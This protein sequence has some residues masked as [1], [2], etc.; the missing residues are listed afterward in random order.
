MKAPLRAAIISGFLHAVAFCGMATAGAVPIVVEGN[1]MDGLWPIPVKC[2]VPFPQGVLKPGEPVV[3]VDGAGVVQSAQT[4]V[5]ATWDPNGEK[6][7]RWL[8]L[9]FLAGK[10]KSYR[11]LFG[12][13][14]AG[15]TIPPTGAIGRI[16]GGI[17][18]IDTG[19]LRATCS[20]RKFDLLASLTGP[21]GRLIADGAWAGAYLEHEKRGIF[22]A[23]L[24]PDA[25]VILEETGPVRA[26]VR[27][28]GWYVNGTGE[29][30]G[31]YIVRV[32]FFRGKADIKVEHTF[33][34]TG[35]AQED[36]LRDIG[37][38][39]PLRQTKTV[40]SY[41]HFGAES[42]GH[43]LT[44]G[45]RNSSDAYF[46]QVQD[47][48]DGHRFEWT[49]RDGTNGNIASNGEM[50]TGSLM[51]NTDLVPVLTQIRDAWQQFPWELEWNKGTL[52]VHLWPKHGRLFDLSWDAQWYYMTDQQKTYL[53]KGKPKVTEENFGE[54]MKRLRG[55]TAQ[56]VA[57][58]HEVWFFFDGRG[59]ISG[60]D[61]VQF[62]V[63]AHAD[64]AWQCASK[65]LDWTV[66]QAY[67]MKNYPDEEDFLATLLDLIKKH[68][69]YVHY[70]GWW[71]WGA[72]H[73]FWETSKNAGYGELGAGIFENTSGERAWHRAK[74]KS[75]YF[76]GMLPW[77]M[78]FRTGDADWLRYSQTYTLYSADRGFK[79]YDGEGVLAGQEYTYD[80]SEIHW[81][82]GYQGVVGGTEHTHNL[83]DRADCIYQYWLT[84]DRRPMDVLRMWAENFDKR[85]D[86]KEEFYQA[87]K[88][89]V[90]NT[91]R[92]TGGR[93]R[94]VTLFYEA[95]WDE[96]FR[97]H[98]ENSARIFPG[99]DSARNEGVW[100]T[101]WLH[102]GLFRY[103]KVFGDERIKQAGIS[104]CL[105]QLRR[106]GMTFEHT[107]RENGLLDWCTF[108]YEYTGDT[109]YL[110][111]G[112]RIV[113]RLVAPGVSRRALHPGAEKF[114]T[115]TLP[116][117]LG[118]MANAPADWRASNLPMQEHP[119]LDFSY[120]G[121]YLP[122]APRIF[123]LKEKDSEFTLEFN[124]GYGGRFVLTAPDGV[125]AGTV[126]I[127]ANENAKDARGR[128]TV[129]KDGKTGVYT[130]RCTE[131]SEK[132]VPPGTRPHLNILRCD[133]SKVVYEMPAAATG[134][135][136]R[137]WCFGV[138]PGKDNI[139][140]RYAPSEEDTAAGIPFVMSQVG[141]NF[142]FDTGT[143]GYQCEYR[144]PIQPTD[145]LRLF[146]CVRKS[147]RH[148]LR[149]V[150]TK[151]MYVAPT[152]A[153]K[154]APSLVST[155]PDA[156][157]VPPLEIL[158]K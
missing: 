20:A 68:T 149:D 55:K 28:E 13:E 97:K 42:N 33:I 131:Y 93:L 51:A 151:G 118:A 111:T 140:V 39:L 27:A 80:N 3:L 17:I 79:H 147:P 57:K 109:R 121:R 40:H 101:A 85:W 4:L 78:Y 95:T 123:M 104:F 73:Q 41:V 49:L 11:L 16:D 64:L 155:T 154:G 112:R 46:Y 38:A 50:A 62:P 21:Q 138:P 98:A 100:M 86:P 103:W 25:R 89:L 135:V 58:T 106:G 26:T 66:H 122:K 24:D 65:A 8:L 153:L 119:T 120:S 158:A 143:A 110:D 136:A 157:F 1:A 114:A 116:R 69:E 146:R 90:G 5:T 18:Q 94:R 54:I 84:G 92:N 81:I 56:G 145:T 87:D 19:A 59:L 7:V 44:V 105:Q 96:R 156:Y 47:C 6:G 53:V 76:W 70:Y 43:A 130:L 31:R 126:F 9:D 113:D 108:G 30:F 148:V 36:R 32:H 63:Y 61:T 141:G 132:D 117:F 91:I 2:G 72:Y 125:Q 45:S 34:F 139:E 129:A 37:I 48:P 127:D 14:A 137:S 23:D 74:P 142:R 128:I 35:L 124:A 102:E 82:G 22:R 52:T 99:A 152:F 150:N 134:F 107:E 144:I 83:M 77:Q 60:Y 12:A 67:D 133:L 115:V 15:K 75:H 29:K 88:A 71:D 10:G